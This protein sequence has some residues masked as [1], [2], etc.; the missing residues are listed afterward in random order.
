MHN[1]LTYWLKDILSQPFSSKKR[2][3]KTAGIPNEVFNHAIFVNDQHYES[4]VAEK[5]I[6]ADFIIIPGAMLILDGPDLG[7][8]FVM[9]AYPCNDHYIASMGRMLRG[10]RDYWWLSERRKKSHIRVKD[11]LNRLARIQAEFIWKDNKLVIKNTGIMEIGIG[12]KLLKRMEQ[13]IV[14]DGMTIYIKPLLFRYHL[15]KPVP[16]Q[17]N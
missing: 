16:K 5:A 8:T 2:K 10:G 1:H 13:A 14:E 17:T 12:D 3:R 11:P 4:L 9:P 6:P 7:K 15:D